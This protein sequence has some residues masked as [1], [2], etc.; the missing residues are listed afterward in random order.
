MKFRRLFIK[1]DSE[2]GKF[3]E[4]FRESNP[5]FFKIYAKKASN[6]LTKICEIAEIGAVQK[7][8]NLVDLEKCYKMSLWSLS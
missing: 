6:I 7:N 8:V 2:Y 5:N 3:C 4:K 1:I